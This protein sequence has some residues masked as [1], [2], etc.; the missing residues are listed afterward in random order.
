M[1][2]CFEAYVGHRLNEDDINRF[3]DELNSNK[4]KSINRF[5]NTYCSFNNTRVVPDQLVDTID[6]IGPN[7][8]SFMF[9]EKVCRIHSYIRWWEFLIEEEIQKHLRKVSFEIMNYFNSSFVIYVPDTGALESYLIDFMWKDENKDV[10]Y[11][12]N[13]LQENCGPPKT[14]IMDIY[15]QFDKYW[16]SDGYFIDVFP[17]I[18]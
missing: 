16:G 6:L 10:N 4:F 7:I 18:K 2:M 15:K 3:C 8:I 11:M 13:W 5:V 9:S 1:G 12:R 17:D 14:R